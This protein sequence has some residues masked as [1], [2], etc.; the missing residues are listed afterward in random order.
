M[1][2]TPIGK[3]IFNLS[4]LK[5]KKIDV[6]SGYAFKSKD[7]TNEGIPIIKIKN[8][9]N[10]VVT[11]DGSQFIPKKIISKKLEKFLLKNN[12]ILIAMTGQG[13]V[14]R[15]GRL[16]IEENIHC[17]LNQRVGKFVLNSQEVYQDYIY[18]ILSTTGYQ[19][20]L[21]NLG[22]GSGQPNLSPDEILKVSIPV[23]PLNLQKSIS[24]IIK[25]LDEKI[26]I[27]KKFNQSTEKLFK[28]IFKSWFLKYNDIKSKS[29]S[30]PKGWKLGRI[31]EL[32]SYVEKGVSPKY[33]EDES[34]PILNQKCIRN[35][36][37]NFNNC[38]FTKYKKSMENKFLG[39][40]DVLVNSMGDGT[41]GRVSLFIN[42]HK[43]TCVDGCIT[44]LRG[45]KKSISF[46]LFQTLS[47]REN[48][49]IKLAK[50][51]TGQTTLDKEDINSLDLIIPD[52][53]TID[54]FFNIAEDFYKSKYKNFL[55]N[56]KLLKI[57]DALI[58]KFISGKLNIINS[59]KIIK[60]LEKQ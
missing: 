15:V 3:S 30:L 25:L 17:Y 6:F 36:E 4:N 24:K 20:Y 60:E 12:D 13:S 59:E 28:K 9:Q 10:K 2:K 46:F 56:N 50:G 53:K 45:K 44:V 38:K 40:F 42:Y 33:T 27:N 54:R 35:T 5:S 8:I 57:K 39:E 21:F 55:E 7:F 43:K 29:A 49:L 11:I 41:L 58:Q 32:A 31:S 23:P 47:L 26:E 51:S 48:Q 19:K 34:Y 14:G 1:N 18:Y 52:Q 22:S 37:V 16:R